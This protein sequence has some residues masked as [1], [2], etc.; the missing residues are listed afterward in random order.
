MMTADQAT[1][2]RVCLHAP[3][4]PAGAQPSILGSVDEDVSDLAAE[5][6]SPALEPSIDDDSAPHAR[7]ERAKDE[8]SIMT[9]VTVTELAKGRGRCVVFHDHR[10]ADALLELAGD[11]YSLE[12]RYVGQTPASTLGVH[13][14]RDRHAHGLRL[15][16]EC[17][18]EPG[19]GVEHH[20]G[21]I[22]RRSF[23]RLLPNDLSALD[24]SSLDARSTEVDTDHRRDFLASCGVGQ[25]AF[26][27]RAQ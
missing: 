20:A 23:H 14:S 6:M 22:S 7:A 24:A 13:L 8:A 26:S 16:V 18:T 10:T 17:Q 3:I 9:A 19:D 15:R 11:R 5:T 21:R 12:S 4:P 25:P 27:D 2:A 1:G